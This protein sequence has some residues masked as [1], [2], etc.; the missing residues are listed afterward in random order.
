MRAGTGAGSQFGRRSRSHRHRQVFTWS[1]RRNRN[2][3]S[4]R[5]SAFLLA[6]PL[7]I[8]GWHGSASP[9]LSSVPMPKQSSGCAGAL[10]QTEIIPPR[11]S[12]SR[13]CWCGSGSRTKRG[14]RRKR[15]L[16]SIQASPFVAFVMPRMHGATIR[17]SLPGATARLRA[18]GWPGCLR[19]DVRVGFN[20]EPRRVQ[21]QCLVCSEE[22]TSSAI[23]LT[24][25]KCRNRLTWRP[26]SKRHH[27]GELRF[28]KRRPIV[29]VYMLAGPAPSP[30]GAANPAYRGGSAR[31]RSKRSAL[32]AGI[33]GAGPSSVFALGYKR[34]FGARLQT[35][36]LPL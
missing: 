25:G 10:T 14:P 27:E 2:L 4:T 13:L 16:R 24:S 18:C 36:G 31:G 20:P 22:R 29:R 34:R 17:P 32:K 12:F 5:H 3:T 11:I 30:A 23:T 28:L 26:S 19:A 33:D 35:S 7:P 9:R 8:D 1:R 6:T 15:D 21:P